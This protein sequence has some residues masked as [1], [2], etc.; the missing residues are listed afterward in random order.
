MSSLHEK[1]S[2]TFV[3]MVSAELYG[4]IKSGVFSKN[5][6]LLMIVKIGLSVLSSSELSYMSNNVMDEASD[7]RDK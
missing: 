4:Y 5:F 7:V 6:L 1:F 2:E 3:Y